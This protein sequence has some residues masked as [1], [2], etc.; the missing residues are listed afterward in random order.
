[1]VVSLFGTELCGRML[2]PLG[3]DNFG[4]PP[5]RGAFWTPDSNMD[6]FYGRPTRMWVSRNA[7][8]LIDVSMLE[9]TRERQ[10]RVWFEEISPNVM[11]LVM[12]RLARPAT[13]GSTSTPSE[14]EDRQE[15]SA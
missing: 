6:D 10:R 1:M 2:M 12:R 11:T 14:G 9:L 4:K 15:A 8:D 3:G 13:A 5:F 7:G